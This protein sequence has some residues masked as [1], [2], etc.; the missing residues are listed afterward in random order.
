MA[1]RFAVIDHIERRF[2]DDEASAMMQIKRWLE[3]DVEHYFD[4]NRI[5]NGQSD[6]EE[7]CEKI[8][9]SG[10]S[11]LTDEIYLYEVNTLRCKAFLGDKDSAFWRNCDG[12]T[13]VLCIERHKVIQD[14]IEL[15][16][17][18]TLDK[19]EKEG[20]LADYIKGLIREAM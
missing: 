19:M 10:A 20:K 11:W 9:K 17:D 12:V 4:I 3:E 8:E 5:Y 15:Q 6:W 13:E 16:Q 14:L 2:F 1:I 18:G 7:T